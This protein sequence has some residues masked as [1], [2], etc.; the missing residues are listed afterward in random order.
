MNKNTMNSKNAHKKNIVN[1]E[2]WI[3][4]YV[5]HM[6][7]WWDFAWGD[8]GYVVCEWTGKLLKIEDEA[9]YGNYFETLEQA[10]AA[11]YDACYYY[12]HE[13]LMQMAGKAS[14]LAA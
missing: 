1:P 5:R 6:A 4:K 2:K 9:D 8:K 12:S 14:V 13:A 3:G 11:G 7:N 10:E